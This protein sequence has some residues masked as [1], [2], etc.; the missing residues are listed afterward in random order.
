MRLLIFITV[1]YITGIIWGLYLKLSIVPIFFIC[2]VIFLGSFKL[3][4]RIRVKIDKNKIPILI[5]VVFAIIS[6]LQITYLENRHDNLYKDKE[7]VKIIGTVI[8]DKNEKSYKASY[9]I[10]VNSI[11]NDRKYKGTNLIIY[12]PKEITLKYGDKIELTGE[13]KKAN[14]NTNY[15]LFNYKE[16]L[17][18]KNI[19]GI[20]NVDKLKVLNENN[21]NKVVIMLNDIRAKIKYNLKVILK[22]ESKI[23]IGILIRRYF[24]YTRRNNR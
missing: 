24:L 12:V 23:A 19:Y 20:V 10:K 4:K 17:K 3:N 2:G 11:N 13:Y 8:S 15:K 22:E 6:N 14:E 7:N 21:L 9:T 16:Y 1:G 5:F 18:T